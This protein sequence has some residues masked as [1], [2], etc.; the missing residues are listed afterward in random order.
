MPLIFT[1]LVA[2]A[3]ADKEALMTIASDPDQFLS[4]APFLFASLLVLAFA[5]GRFSLDAA[6]L[7]KTAVA[8]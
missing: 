6:L 7:R 2:Y 3:T 4:A 8:G 1:M 5:P